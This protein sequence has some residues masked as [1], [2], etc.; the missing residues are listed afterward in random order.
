MS[1]PKLR[2]DEIAM[3]AFPRALC[4]TT[5]RKMSSRR[6]HYAV[7]GWAIWRRTAD[8]SRKP[9]RLAVHTRCR[10]WISMPVLV[11][12]WPV[13]GEICDL[14]MLHQ[15]RDLAARVSSSQVDF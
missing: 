1:T 4:V 13:P 9:I 12:D 11:N 8:G 3:T 15:S 10:Q 5:T 6:Y 7:G 2:D 14:C